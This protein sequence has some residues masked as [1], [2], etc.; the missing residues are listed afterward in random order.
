LGEFLTV[1]FA[2]V[3]LLSVQLLVIAPRMFR[4]YNPVERNDQAPECPRI[5]FRLPTFP[6]S[7]KT[8]GT[9]LIQER[10]E[11]ESLGIDGY[12][13]T[14]SSGGSVRLHVMPPEQTQNIFWAN[15]NHPQCDALFV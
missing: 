12:Y 14:N 8:K 5:R 9:S 13:V 11:P 4:Y 2:I 10:A 6:A 15:L 3:G 1:A 7:L